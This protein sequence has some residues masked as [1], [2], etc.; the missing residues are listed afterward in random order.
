MDGWMICGLAIIPTGFLVISDF[1]KGGMNK[2]IMRMTW[3]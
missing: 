1:Q 3:G 2:M